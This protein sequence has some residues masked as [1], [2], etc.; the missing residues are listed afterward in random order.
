MAHDDYILKTKLRFQS[1]FLYYA[2]K[3]VAKDAA[4]AIGIPYPMVTAW[5]EFLSVSPA[6][7]DKEYKEA[8][9]DKAEGSV[10]LDMHMKTIPRKYQ[11][12]TDLFELAIPDNM[13]SIKKSESIRREMREIAG[14]VKPKYLKAKGRKP[15]ELDEK[16]RRF[17]MYTVCC[18]TG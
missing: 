7:Q 4:L 9:V 18:T 11:S 5:H 15:Y 2:T 17:H 12:Y 6:E 13:F 14:T 3:S 10:P 16:T 8:D 1:Q